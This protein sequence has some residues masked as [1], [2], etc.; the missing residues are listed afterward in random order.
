MTA[1]KFKFPTYKTSKPI[2]GNNEDILTATLTWTGTA[3]NILFS[4]GISETYDGVYTFEEVSA[5][6]KHTFTASG[7]WIK[8]RAVGIKAFVDYIDVQVNS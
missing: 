1:G 2:W 8:W 3:D 6:I 4:L 5:S 7:K